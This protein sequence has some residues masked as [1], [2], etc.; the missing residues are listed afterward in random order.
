[1]VWMF[2][3]GCLG[4]SSC[5][6]CE[7]C[8]PSSLIQFALSCFDHRC[9]FLFLFPQPVPEEQQSGEEFGYLVA[10]RPLGSSTWI[11]TVLASADVSRY[12]YRNDSVAPLSRFEATVGVFNSMGEGPFSRI[13]K[14]FSA[15]EGEGF[16]LGTGRMHNEDGDS[17]RGVVVLLTESMHNSCLS[18]TEPSA[19]PS[20]V[21]AHS[22]S[23]SE[24]EVYWE[25]VPP[26]SSTE[27]IIG[28]E[29]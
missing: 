7:C 25:P 2:L 14:V 16:A 10:F 11:K 24:I 27:N 5:R 28:Y 26:R 22:I 1:M 4:K 18:S 15:E 3:Q 29:V 6:Q 19:A 21:W 12:V 13:V 8:R 9:L 20:R 23:A 17:R